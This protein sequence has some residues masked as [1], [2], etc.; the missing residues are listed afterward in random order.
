MSPSSQMA[1][2]S[3]SGN[4]WPGNAC[5]AQRDAK[6]LPSPF[7]VC[8]YAIT[9]FFFI[10]GKVAPDVRHG[11]MDWTAKGYCSIL[12]LWIAFLGGNI[13]FLKHHGGTPMH[14]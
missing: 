4:H 10:L 14:V 2:G 7:S 8:V 11:S 6:G 5:H 12:T 13:H 1:S 3:N 9:C